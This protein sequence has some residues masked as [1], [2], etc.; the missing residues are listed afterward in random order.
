MVLYPHGRNLI[1]EVIKQV[2][3][4]YILGWFNELYHVEAVA[5]AVSLRDASAFRVFVKRYQTGPS[6]LQFWGFSDIEHIMD[7]V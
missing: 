5:Q 1:E 6:F 2:H 7:C 3:I 4:M